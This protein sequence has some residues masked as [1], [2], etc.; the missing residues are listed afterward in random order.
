MFPPG[1]LDKAAEVAMQ[2][3]KPLCFDYYLASVNGEC[4]IVQAQ[5]DDAQKK[6]KERKLSKSS[7]EYTS[8]LVRLLKIPPARENEKCEHLLCETYNSMYIVHANIINVQRTTQ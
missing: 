7:D 5:S 4:N 8:P 3:D 2:T 1:C 6:T